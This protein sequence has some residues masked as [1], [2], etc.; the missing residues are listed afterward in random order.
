MATSGIAPIP[1]VW[2]LRPVKRAWR[3]GAHRAVVWNRLSLS[4]RAA[5]RSAVGVLMA[6]PKV[7]AAPKPMSSSKMMS[8]LGEPSGG[9]TSVIGGKAVSGSF[10]S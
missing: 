8:T 6:P 5:R 2:W 7:E 10:A 9:C 3:L 4:P 1:A